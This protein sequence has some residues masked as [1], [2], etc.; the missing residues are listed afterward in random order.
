M[1]LFSNELNRPCVRFFQIMLFRNKTK[2][3]KHWYQSLYGNMHLT[4]VKN[5]LNNYIAWISTKMWVIKIKLRVWFELGIQSW[6]RG[7]HLMATVLVG[8]TFVHVVVLSVHIST[9]KHYH[10]SITWCGYILYRIYMFFWIAVG[11]FENW[12]FGG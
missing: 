1:C 5:D 10:N 3:F 7:Y 12:N 9:C 2:V 6:R 8:R 11:K 4:F